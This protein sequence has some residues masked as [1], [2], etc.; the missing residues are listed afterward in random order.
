MAGFCPYRRQ[1]TLHAQFISALELKARLG[2][3]ATTENL[4]LPVEGERRFPQNRFEK[5][6]EDSIAVGAV[7]HDEKAVA[8]AEANALMP[9]S[10]I[11]SAFEED[12]SIGRGVQSPTQSGTQFDRVV[13]GRGL[14]GERRKLVR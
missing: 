1:C 7:C 9:P 13:C 10:V 12:I 3:F 4:A 2:L 5:G 6:L 14:R 11:V 8:I